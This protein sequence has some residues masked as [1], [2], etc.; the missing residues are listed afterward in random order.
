MNAE[1]S[2]A[3]NSGAAN[4]DDSSVKGESTSTHVWSCNF[5]IVAPVSDVTGNLRVDKLVSWNVALT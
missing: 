2:G 1:E 4:N 3:C 5:Y